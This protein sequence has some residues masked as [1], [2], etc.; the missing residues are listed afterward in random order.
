MLLLSPS[1]PLHEPFPVHREPPTPAGRTAR[2]AP[3]PS[4]NPP[5]G[6]G[7]EDSTNEWTRPAPV[8]TPYGINGRL[9]PDP[10]PARRLAQ[11]HNTP[12]HEAVSA[13][14]PVEP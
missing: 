9:F 13:R 5:D 7:R 10:A 3:F 11:D 12:L 8:P 14:F 6:P 1:G 2:L 4:E